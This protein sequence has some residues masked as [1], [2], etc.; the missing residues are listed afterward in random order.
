MKAAHEMNVFRMTYVEDARDMAEIPVGVMVPHAGGTAGGLVGF[1]AASHSESAQVVQK[2]IDT[3]RA[4]NDGIICL[5]HGGPFA[6][7]K[8]TAYLYEHT[9]ALGFVGTSSMKRIP[10][11]KAVTEFVKESKSVPLKRKG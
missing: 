4:V 2:M 6:V 9:S 7:P 1:R 5:V 3:T 8:V 11:E 10:I